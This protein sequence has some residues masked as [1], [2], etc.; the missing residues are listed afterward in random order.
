MIPRVVLLISPL[1]IRKRRDLIPEEQ[2]IR[3]LL[4]QPRISR[5]PIPTPGP[6]RP[7]LAHHNPTR[8]ISGCIG[9]EGDPRPVILAGTDLTRLQLN[10]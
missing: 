3:S 7:G 8:S 5:V 4:P 2:V 10:D 9:V 1:I 6:N